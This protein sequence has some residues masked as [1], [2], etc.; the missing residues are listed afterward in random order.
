MNGQ[1]RNM[2]TI[3]IKNDNKF[4]LLDRIGSKVIERS[5]CG[6]G[7]HFEPN[8]INDARTAVLR[9]MNEEIGITKKDLKNLDLRYVALR[10][11][12]GELRINYYFFADLKENAQ[13]NYN[14]NEG[15]LE[16]VSFDEANTKKMPYIAQKVIEHY[17]ETGIDTKNFYSVTVA[18][19]KVNI[20]S[21]GVL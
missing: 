21:M 9:E 7:G 5:W 14:C 17:L 2:A 12:K 20:I 11:V 19:E 3:Y 16:W 1:L 15:I 13:I 18:D 4:L 8:E 10:I 6:V